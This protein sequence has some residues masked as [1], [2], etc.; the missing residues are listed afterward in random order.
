MR[1]VEAREREHLGRHSLQQ[2]CICHSM[3]GAEHVP[4]LELK[5]AC[6]TLR[7]AC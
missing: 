6:S 2:Q 4:F 5:T 7:W 1:M 3:L